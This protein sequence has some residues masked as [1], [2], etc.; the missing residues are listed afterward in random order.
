MYTQPVKDLIILNKW[1]G[2][3]SQTFTKS[4]RKYFQVAR[5]TSGQRR[6]ANTGHL[7]GA[8]GEGVGVDEAEG[9]PEDQGNILK[10][11]L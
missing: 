2:S 11:S 4:T 8:E 1:E 9:Q 3:Q 7:R 6:G 10:I 5:R